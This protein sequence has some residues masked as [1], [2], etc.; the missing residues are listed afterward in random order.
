[1]LRLTRKWVPRRKRSSSSRLGYEMF[2]GFLMVVYFYEIVSY[3][4]GAGNDAILRK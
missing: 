1:M 2:E 4:G 3:K